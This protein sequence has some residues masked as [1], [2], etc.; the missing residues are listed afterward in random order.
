MARRR[1]LL[2]PVQALQHRRAVLQGRD[3]LGAVAAQR[4]FLDRHRARQ[5]GL[6]RAPGTPFALQQ[7][8]IVQA[9]GEARV[10]GPVVRLLDHDH[11][12][13]QRQRRLVVAAPT[14]QLAQIGQHRRQ[15]GRACAQQP[16]A[17]GQGLAQQLACPLDLPLPDQRERQRMAALCRLQP[18]RPQG[19][20]P[21]GDGPL[22]QPHRLVGLALRHQHLRQIAQRERH[23][24]VVGA[25]HRLLDRQHL[26]L[27]LGGGRQVAHGIGQGT[28]V[29]AHLG[30][31]GVPLAQGLDPDR[32]GLGEQGLR[33][34]EA[35]LVRQQHAQIVQAFRE[36][37]ML[38]RQ[39]GA[40]DLDRPAMQPLGL[41]A[42]P[43]R[44][45]RLGQIVQ[46]LCR[47]RMG[48]PQRRVAHRQR[49]GIVGQG[50][51]GAALRVQH[52]AQIVGTGRAAR[53]VRRQLLGQRQSLAER[54]LGG[55]EVA[56]I[57]AGD[58][59]LADALP[60][61]RRILGQR[62]PRQ[63]GE[64]QKELSR[65]PQWLRRGLP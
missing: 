42:L 6:G 62:R 30:H 29:A 19:R 47:H 17:G 53:V 65:V 5:Q 50:L 20:H 26:A 4:L 48:R 24:G 7:R 46:A 41:L 64:R 14:L 40:A 16:L 23:L 3:Q 8:Q 60:L 2:A 51:A 1:R 63:Q 21:D 11:P 44:A 15:L 25:A 31:G 22:Q 18:V 57:G 13:Q 34:V 52:E 36:V 35:L 56:R 32:Q 43:F 37:G 10:L 59:R 55:G 45:Q 38:R 39:A 54:P 58:P 61:G 27:P 49:V 28:Q 33:L 12:L 9:D